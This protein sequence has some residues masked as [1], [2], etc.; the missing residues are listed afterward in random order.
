VAAR[1]YRD[2]RRDEPAR[3]RGGDRPLAPPEIVADAAHAILVRPSRE[4]IGNLFGDEDVLAEEGITDL[5]RYRAAP[6]DGELTTDL[7]LD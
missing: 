4:C 3:R 7:F 2:G 1:A 6:E 5:D